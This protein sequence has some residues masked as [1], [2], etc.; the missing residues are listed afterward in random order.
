MIRYQIIG[1][2][3][4]AR[5]RDRVCV[6]PNGCHLRN[7]NMMMHFMH[8]VHVYIIILNL[9]NGIFLQC[10][11]IDLS[12]F[13][14]RRKYI[15]FN[16]PTIKLHNNRNVSKCSIH[17][18]RILVEMEKFWNVN[19]FLEVSANERCAQIRNLYF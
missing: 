1:F 18:R 9:P 16:I 15:Q 3:L 19:Q 2:D 11:E 8:Y 7:V 6:H 17:I 12:C 13:S 14:T 4:E 10:C 5:R